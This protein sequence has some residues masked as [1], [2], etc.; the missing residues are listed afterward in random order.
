MFYVGRNF[1][2]FTFN[3][4]KVASSLMTRCVYNITVTLPALTDHCCCCY[5]VRLS[6]I[7]PGLTISVYDTLIGLTLLVYPLA[8]LARNKQTARINA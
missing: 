7:N 5:Y 2:H 6:G 8:R 4:T 3:V 1:F